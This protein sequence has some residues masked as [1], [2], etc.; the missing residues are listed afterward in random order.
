MGKIPITFA[1][2]IIWMAQIEPKFGEVIKHEQISKVLGLELDEIDTRFNAQEV[3]TGLP[4]IIV[5]LKTLGSIRRAKIQSEKY[6]ELISDIE[7][8]AI[9]T[10]CPETYNSKN[11]LNV[12]VFANYYGVPEDPATGSANG[13]LAGYLIKNRYFNSNQINVH[14]EQG[15]EMGRP[16]LL[17]LNAKEEKEKI[18]IFVGGNVLM[19]A[20]GEFT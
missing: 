18:E 10:F 20:K 3:S 11:E 17:I 15:Y 1:N 16:S 5:P 2:E 7:A 4:F 14:V 12:R 13:C 19:V 9:L 8:K 6:H